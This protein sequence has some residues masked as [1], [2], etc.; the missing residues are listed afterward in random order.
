MFTMMRDQAREGAEEKS[1]A[2]VQ[3]MQVGGV[4]V[5]EA[6]ERMVNVNAERG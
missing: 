2:Q 3:R 6:E 4:V 1:G 5:R